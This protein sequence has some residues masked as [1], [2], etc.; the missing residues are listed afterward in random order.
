MQ[1]HFGGKK[2]LVKAKTHPPS[3]DLYTILLLPIFFVEWQNRGGRGGAIYCAILIAK[4]NVGG[5]AIK[6]VLNAKN[7]ID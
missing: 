7:S 1:E 4:Y 2:Y 3:L 5:F 6:E